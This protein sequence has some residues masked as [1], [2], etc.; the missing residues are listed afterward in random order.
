MYENSTTLVKELIQSEFNARSYEISRVLKDGSVGKK[1][2]WHVSNIRR[3]SAFDQV[4][5]MHQ[6]W[7]GEACLTSGDEACRESARLD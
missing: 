6:T 7:N 2:K 3:Q 5:P 1:V 4:I